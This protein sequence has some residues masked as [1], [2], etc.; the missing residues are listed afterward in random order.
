MQEIRVVYPCNRG[1]ELQKFHLGLGGPH[2]NCAELRV[3]HK[4]ICALRKISFAPPPSLVMTGSL[5]TV[6]NQD[7]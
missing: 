3:G 5:Q 2:R 7:F 6:C 4:N 1:G